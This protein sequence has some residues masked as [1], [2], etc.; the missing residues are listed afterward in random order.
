[1]HPGIHAAADPDKPAVIMAGSGRVTTYRQL[2]DGAHRAAHALRAAGAAPGDH[3]AFQLGNGPAFFELLWAAQRSGLV[4]T[5]VSTRLGP[6]E[7]AYIVADCGATVFVTDAALAGVVDTLGDG[8]LGDGVA[9]H[10]AGGTANGWR[11]WE[12]ALALAPAGPLLG[13]YA[14][15]DM[16]Y[17]SGT[18]GRPKGVLHPLAAAAIDE[19]DPLTLG[20]QMVWG[21][22]ADTVYL[23]PAPLYH[24][25]PLRFT[26]SVHRLGGTVV[27]MEHFDAAEL[28]RLIGRYGVTAAQVV[29]TMFI[30]MLAL[31]RA[32]RAAAE[33]TTL[34]TVIHAAAPCP[35][36]VKQRMIEWWGPIIWEYYAGTEAN[37]MLLCDAQEWLA[38]P[39]TV[40]QPRGGEVHIVGDDGS[41]VPPRAIGTVYLGGGA[42]FEYLN[43]PEGTAACRH[44]NGWTT[45]G[46][47]GY[48]DEDGYLYLTD[49]KADMI[50]SGGVNVYPQE[51]ENVLAAHPEVADVAVFGVPDED[52]GEVPLA[53]V[54][55]VSMQRAGPELEQELLT[56]CRDRLAHYK[57]PTSVDFEA[58]LPRHPTGKLYKRLLR[59]RYREGP[60]AGDEQA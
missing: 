15:D 6:E 23:S 47:I 41:E 27:S 53:V 16:L 13:P 31:P 57:C 55:P 49:R 39:G 52:L 40:G 34:R 50:I 18:T 37:G 45:L 48:L 60:A 56:Y 30:R 22:G 21:M 25:A 8:R 5:A 59:D 44:P 29:P 17:S 33:L 24:A 14:G 12:E 32:Q 35:V 46:D 42:P 7:T 9:C 38:H 20:C 58:A 54:E 26:R 19:P 28:L 36:P 51:A 11:S 3:V 4:Y 10:L 43:D 2:D 1:M